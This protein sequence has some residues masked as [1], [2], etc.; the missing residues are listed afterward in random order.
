MSTAW[1]VVAGANAQRNLS[2]DGSSQLILGAYYRGKDAVI[3]VVFSREHINLL[4]VT[5][6]LLLL[7]RALTAAKGV[8]SFP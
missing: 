7:S 1:E 2:G 6:Q 5:M 8:M 4:L 3:P